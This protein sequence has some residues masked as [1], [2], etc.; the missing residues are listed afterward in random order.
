MKTQH[1]Q[2]IKGKKKEVEGAQR[3][4]LSILLF[5]QWP[6]FHWKFAPI[7]NALGGESGGT[8]IFSGGHF[9]V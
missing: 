4:T 5:F 2:K 6:I 7:S 9:T 1:S 3:Q 8:E